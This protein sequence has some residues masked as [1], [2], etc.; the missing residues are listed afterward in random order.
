MRTKIYVLLVTFFLLLSVLVVSVQGDI[1]NSESEEYSHLNSKDRHYNSSSGNYEELPIS[2]CE[3]TILVRIEPM[4][5]DL[6]RTN[7]IKGVLE[8]QVEDLLNLVEGKISRLY[9]S[10]N[11]AEITLKEGTEVMN[12]IDVL[13]KREEVVHAEP[14]YLVEKSNIP[15]D[16]GYDSLWAMEKIDAPGAWDITTGSEEVVVPVLDTGIDYNHPDLKDNMWTSEDG[17]HGYNAVNDSYYP[18]DDHGH[19]THV[20]GTIGAVGNNEEGVVGVNW[21]VSLMGVKILDS[22]GSGTLADILS[23]LDYV[24]ERKR[25]GE[26]IVVT[27]NSWWGRRRSDLVYEA[28]EQHLE[29]GI[30]FVTAAGNEGENNGERPSYPGNY[31]LPNI[32]SVAATNQDDELA[33]FSNYGKRSVHVGAPGVDI[34]STWS[35]GEYSSQRGTSMAVP[36]VSGLV[37]LLASHDPSYDYNNLKNIIL[38]SADSSDPLQ[39]QTLVGGRINASN[40]IEKS[41]DPEEVN[42][43]VHRPYIATQWRERT[44]ITISLNDGV[45]P[46]EGADVRVEFSTDEDTIELVD[47]GSGMDQIAGDGYYTGGWTPRSRGEV[48]LTITVQLDESDKEMTENIT[49]EVKLL[50]RETTQRLLERVFNFVADVIMYLGDAIR[51][52]LDNLEMSLNVAYHRRREYHPNQYEIINY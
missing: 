12:A 2:Y 8:N 26:N 15:N 9:P 32:I 31:D 27:S 37:A 51:N 4:D 28:I 50:H 46:I 21:N 20:A 17:H 1:A 11:T 5:E 19:G 48:N 25:D 13:R 16:P 39:N 29:E 40:A 33:G 52:L 14:N 3:E 23:G 35:D 34:N 6:L 43:W 44:R 49:V 42:F 38:S 47:D 36:H 41:P 30:L 45:N 24:L 10:I 18:M 22:E 7:D